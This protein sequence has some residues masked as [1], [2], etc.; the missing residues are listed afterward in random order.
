MEAMT[1]LSEAQALKEQKFARFRRLRHS[2]L[3]R[4]M[5]ADVILHPSSF[6]LPMF[7]RDGLGIRQEVPSMPGVYQLSPDQVVQ[8][9]KA[10]EQ[11]G[12]KAFILFGVIEKKAK[13]EAGSAAIDP[14]NI[15]CH[16]LKIVKNSGVRM[17]A[18]TDLCFCEYTS[19]GHCGV[20]K[21]ASEHSHERIVANDA[22]LERL[23]QQA[24]NH[25]RAGADMVAPS[26]MMDG[27]VAVVRNALD[28]EGFPHLPILSYAVKYASAFYGP[29]RDAADSTPAFGDRCSYQ[30]DGRRHREALLEARADLEQG[31]DILM[32]KP[33][34]PYLDILRD[35]RQ[36]FDVPLAAYQ[37]SGE[38]AMIKAA[39]QNGWV[40]EKAVML[41]SLVSLKRAGADLILTYFAREAVRELV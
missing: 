31:A 26:A 12:L 24:V 25:A 30:M 13:D 32:V 39:A 10:A 34:L 23:A 5:V 41:E 35:L 40:D 1:H 33:G 20:L 9:L 18:I 21:P 17:I 15:I 8:D 22:T 14:D 4:E 36:A 6:I 37:V 3:L 19:H 2:P 38:Y 28:G 16:T 7:V 29:F 27:M 11:L